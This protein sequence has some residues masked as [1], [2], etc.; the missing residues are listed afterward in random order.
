MSR[1]KEVVVCWTQWL[2]EF[3]W[4]WFAH[5]TFRMPLS[6]KGAKRR[7]KKWVSTLGTLSTPYA[8][9]GYERGE[10][11]GCLHAH[12]L[13]GGVSLTPVT[14]A[15]STWFEPNGRALIEPLK[16]SSGIKYVCK[17]AVKDDLL[18]FY[19][20]LQKKSLDS[21]VDM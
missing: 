19:G 17:Y 21:R 18:E 6:V 10:R 16:N 13:V 15:W 4:D 5:L 14:Q 7:V 2:E 1:E 12:A 11:T 20:P 3:D 8:V 9:V